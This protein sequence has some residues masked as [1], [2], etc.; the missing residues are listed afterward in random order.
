MKWHCVS[1]LMYADDI[2]LLAPSVLSLQN[3]LTLCEI[4]LLN[5]AVIK[6]HIECCCS[7]TGRLVS[8]NFTLMSWV[9]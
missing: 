4:E 3:L 8:S 1:I 5:I 6:R 7:A 2:L 9:M